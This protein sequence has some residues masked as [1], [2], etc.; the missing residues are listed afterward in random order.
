[1]IWTCFTEKILNS[2]QKIAMVLFVLQDEQLRENVEGDS[3][4]FAAI[5]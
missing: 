4:L 3:T 1:M 5:K 2:V